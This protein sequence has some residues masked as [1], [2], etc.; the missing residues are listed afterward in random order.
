MRNA[1]LIF[2][3]VLGVLDFLYGIVAGDRI[4]LIAGSAIVGIT[5]YIWKTKGKG[6]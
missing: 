5:V 3:I 6:S 4:S 2:F 1:A